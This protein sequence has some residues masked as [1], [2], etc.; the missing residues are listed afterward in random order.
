PAE[1]ESAFKAW[2]AFGGLGART[3]RGCGAVHCE[4]T[5]SELPQLPAKVFIGTPK[6]NAIEAWKEAVKAYR[7]FRQSPRGRR[8]DKTINTMKGPKLIQVPRR[9]HW[10]EAD[11]IRQITECALKPSLDSP[12]SGIPADEDTQDHSTPVV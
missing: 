2:V 12:S 10:P 11:S 5:A 7:D 3:R 6:S 1:V 9:S 8:H 4:T